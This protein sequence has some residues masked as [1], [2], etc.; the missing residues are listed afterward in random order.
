MFIGG[1]FVIVSLVFGSE[2]LAVAQLLPLS[3][4]GALLIFAGAQLAMTVQDITDRKEYFV[5]MAILGITLASNLAFGLSGG[6]G[7]ARAAQARPV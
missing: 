5:C 7:P 1:I 3:V 4:L 2:V 6:H